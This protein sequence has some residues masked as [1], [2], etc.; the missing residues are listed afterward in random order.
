MANKIYGPG[1]V[2]PGLLSSRGYKSY[3]DGAFQ[4]LAVVKGCACE[5]VSCLHIEALNLELVYVVEN[6]AG[7]E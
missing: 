6:D 3:C 1:A 4:P 7:T 5:L 2:A